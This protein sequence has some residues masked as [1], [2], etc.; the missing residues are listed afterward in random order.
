MRRNE[1]I[2]ALEYR[3]IQ[4][5][6]IG[7]DVKDPIVKLRLANEAYMDARK[8]PSSGTATSSWT[9][10]KGHCAHSKTPGKETGKVSGTGKSIDFLANFLLPNH[11]DSSQHRSACRRA[12][13]WRCPIGPARLARAKVRGFD[14]LTQHEADIIISNFAR[15]SIGL[16]VMALG[17]FMPDVF[18]GNY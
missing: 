4:S 18:G 10:I 8:H 7:L 17:F 5:E 6:R 13:P 12:Q 2:K 16:G 15:G 3:A 14:T 1:F 9:P 11:S